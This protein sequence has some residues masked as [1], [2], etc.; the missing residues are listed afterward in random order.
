MS[1]KN[2]FDDK[3]KKDQKP[4]PKP[5]PKKNN[6]SSFP[7]EGK[8]TDFTPIN[9]SQNGIPLLQMY[10]VPDRNKKS[11]SRKEALIASEAI[12]KTLQKKYGTK[13]DMQLSV[14]VKDTK[15]GWRRNVTQSIS[16]PV[17]LWSRHF[18][19]MIINDEEFDDEI[20]DDKFSA[21]SFFLHIS[22]KGAGST[23]DELNDCVYNCLK[24]IDDFP[25]GSPVKFKNMLGKK[26][27]DKIQ[28]EDIPKIESYL[29]N[30]KINVTGDVNY[31][32]SKI[33]PKTIN[34]IFHSEHCTLENTHLKKMIIPDNEKN[35]YFYYPDGDDRFI[36]YK[37][38]FSV[39][40][41]KTNDEILTKQYKQSTKGV[42]KS[43]N[44]YIKHTPKK[45]T[46]SENDLSENEQSLLQY[47][48]CKNEHKKFINDVI[49]LKEL[50]NN[51]INI[52]KTG[53]FYKTALKYFYET[54]QF[55]TPDKILRDEALWIRYA[56]L[57]PI[58]YCEKGYKGKCH[59]QDF[60]SFYPSI[61]MR[62][63]TN[64]PI[65][66]GEFINLSEEDF[67]NMKF[68][69]FG[70]Y[71]AV[72]HA[73]H[74][75]FRFN[76]LNYYTHTDMELAK[77]L[78][79]PIKLICDDQANFLHYSHDKLISGKNLFSEFVKTLYPLRKEVNIVKPILNIL[80]GSLGQIN[81]VIKDYYSNKQ[82]ELPID[83]IIEEIYMKNDNIIH[84]KYTQKDKPIFKT[85]FARIVP[86]LLAYGRRDMIQLIEPFIND[87]VY[88]RTD[89]FRTKTKQDLKFGL[90]IG[91]LFY[92]GEEFIKIEN[93]NLVFKK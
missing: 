7:F 44:I 55:I 49:K 60:K 52:F 92:E 19:D 68:Y 81:T 86:Y 43:N 62:Q 30:Y 4:K 47:E 38:D 89:G 84:V 8:N 82:H 33:A 12:R 59:Y 69:K 72:I 87:V 76:E 88:V 80:W 67:N 63:Q 29:K 24:D 2:F 36:L 25:F 23:D 10:L 65:K 20:A 11:F 42:N 51:K 37:N 16:Q 41:I 70:I 50:S 90:D 46:N 58:L 27:M 39:P 91:E 64:Y 48:Y 77:K 6:L 32:S 85:D 15:F 13:H 61:M 21:L 17:L 53:T 83:A 93:I 31:F 57:G 18:Y 9:L 3:M 5:K 14:S 78:K 35:I 40:E 1:K 26:R 74:K 34:L 73:C 54:V 71:R 56:T 45:L 79:L 75:L 28:I 22:K 66:R